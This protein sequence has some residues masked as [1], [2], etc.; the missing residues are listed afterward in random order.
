MTQSRLE[1]YLD[2]TLKKPEQQTED[3]TDVIEFLDPI[4]R[5][6]IDV[7][8]EELPNATV[9]YA[10]RSLSYFGE[11][12]CNIA[13]WKKTDTQQRLGVFTVPLADILADDP[14]VAYLQNG[15]SEGA[16]DSRVHVEA[17]EDEV[18]RI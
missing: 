15:T 12:C 3:F 9:T 10:V 11:P 8:C 1:A 17:V 5:R 16:E 14:V 7:M 13:W 18:R 2:S 6:L 4:V